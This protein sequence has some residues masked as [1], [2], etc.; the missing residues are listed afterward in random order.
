MKRKK[1]WNIKEAVFCEA[2]CYERKC[3]FIVNEV[4]DVWGETE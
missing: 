2:W 4:G 3:W 1:G